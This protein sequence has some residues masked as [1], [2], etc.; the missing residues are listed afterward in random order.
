M[1]DS[2]RFFFAAT[3]RTGLSW[4]RNGWVRSRV[5]FRQMPA[6]AAGRAA[7]AEMKSEAGKSLTGQLLVA[8]PQM[9]DPRFAR[10]VVYVCAHSEDEGDGPRDQQAACAADGG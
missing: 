5:R 8:M 1:H 9:M 10:S 3:A 2:R 7:E 4:G 6:E